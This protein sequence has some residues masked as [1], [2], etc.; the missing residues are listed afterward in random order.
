MHGSVISFGGPVESE[1]FLLHSA[2]VV[3]YAFQAWLELQENG[4]SLLADMSLVDEVLGGEYEAD[5][6][7]VCAALHR[8]V[9]VASRGP[10]VEMVWLFTS[11]ERVW[12]QS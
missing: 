11:L 4:A 7:M 8:L 10:F 6:E 5:R 9:E 1:E 12:A 2:E 3:F